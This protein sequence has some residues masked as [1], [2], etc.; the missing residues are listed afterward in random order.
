MDA[1]DVSPSL[2]GI[3]QLTN[4]GVF[5]ELFP[6]RGTVFVQHLS[7]GAPAGGVTVTLY[8]NIGGNGSVRAV[9]AVCATA[10]TASNGEAVFG[11][12][13]LERCYAG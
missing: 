11:G 12:V 9:P 3:A 5:S 13:D 2:A 4:L 10:S 7:D 6:E 8:R 1:A